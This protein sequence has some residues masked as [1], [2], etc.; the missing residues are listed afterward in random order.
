MILPLYQ[1]E[2]VI[3]NHPLYYEIAFD[4]VDI[5][6]QIELFEEAMR[7][8]SSRKLESVFDVACGPSLQLREL[9]RQGYFVS[10]L[11]KSWPM[12]EYLS[13]KLDEISVKYK[14]H[15]GDMGNFISDYRFDLAFTLMGS[16]HYLTSN[17]D[18]LSHLYSMSRVINKGGLYLIENLP[19]SGQ[20]G[21]EEWTKIRGDITVKASYRT[22]MLNG[23]TQ[24][25][26]HEFNLE[27]IDGGQKKEIAQKF[28][29]KTMFPQEFGWLVKQNDNFDL[30][31]F[32][33]RRNKLFL[34]ICDRNPEN[35]VILRRK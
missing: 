4:F 20:G 27:V 13:S 9:A 32:F 2:H 19:I 22:T 7:R 3:Y 8:F 5:P 23:I 28:I 12:V 15:Y 21:H 18:Y 26:E 14:M 16:I 6:A 25:E 31:G 29:T 33:Q 24:A 11:D 1:Y 30:I 34:E 17:R 10:G 35:L